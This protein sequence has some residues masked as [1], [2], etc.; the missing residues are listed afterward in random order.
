MRTCVA[1]Q[2]SWTVSLGSALAVLRRWQRLKSGDWLWR[3]RRDNCPNKCYV[4]G[5]RDTRAVARAPRAQHAYHGV[6]PYSGP[7]LPLC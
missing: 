2:R 1:S 4:V 3:A 5:A 7:R 6:F